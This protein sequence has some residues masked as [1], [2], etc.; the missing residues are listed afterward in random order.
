MSATQEVLPVSAAQGVIYFPQDSG[1]GLC[2]AGAVQ[3]SRK[4]LQQTAEHIAGI[5]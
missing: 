5:T 2:Q 1:L 4:K 3:I